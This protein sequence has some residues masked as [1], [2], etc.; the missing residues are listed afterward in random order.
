MASS[1]SLEITCSL[2][3]IILRDIGMVEEMT[4]LTEYLRQ[5]LSHLVRYMYCTVQPLGM[6]MS[7]DLTVH[8]AAITQ[9][10]LPLQRRW[11]A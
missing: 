6:I 1:S 4:S 11:L 3:E 7:D 10:Q 2:R 8:G 5:T 9:Q